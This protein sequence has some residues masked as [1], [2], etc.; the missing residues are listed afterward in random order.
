MCKIWIQRKRN[1]N[2]K[3]CEK[4]DKL[5]G[6]YEWSGMDVWSL[7]D[8]RWP[9]YEIN[10]NRNNNVVGWKRRKKDSQTSASMDRKFFAPSD[11]RTPQ[12]LGKTENDASRNVASHASTFYSILC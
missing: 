4:K 9:G 5:G 3:I 8:H 11:G 1:T 2:V 12:K 6:S 7:P 10:A